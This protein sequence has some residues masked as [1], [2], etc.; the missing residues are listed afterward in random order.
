MLLLATPVVA[1]HAEDNDSLTARY[2]D[3]LRKRGLYT[4]AENYAESRL[5]DP[6]LTAGQRSEFAIQLSRT[7]SAH[8]AATG[9]DQQDEIWQRAAGVIEDALASAKEQ[10]QRIFLEAAAAFVLAARSE[11]LVWD[12]E[13]SPF[14]EP[15]RETLAQ[16]SA[17]ALQK[18]SAVETSL[19]GRLKSLEGK[20]RTSA[21]VPIYA[22]RRVAIQV[23]LRSALVLQAK[24][25]LSPAG[26]QDR[27][28]D[29]VSAD[30]RYRKVVSSG[31]PDEQFAAKLGLITSNRLRDELDRAFEMLDALARSEK[32]AVDGRQDAIRLERARVLLMSRRPDAAGKEL[33]IIQAGRTQL[34]G[35]FWFVQFQ[36]LAAIKRLANERGSQAL[37]EE[38][39]E[40]ATAALEEVDQQVGGVWSR[41]CRAIWSAAESVERYGQRLAA[42]VAQ[43][44]G[45]YVAGRTEAAIAAYSTAA[46]LAQESNQPD[47]AM[48]LGATLTG[49]LAQD[50]RWEELVR[51]SRQLIAAN[52]A[53]AK[54]AEIDLLRIYGLGR[55]LDADPTEEHRAAYAQALAD[56]AR[57]YA[58][59]STISEVAYLQGRLAETERQTGTA[60]A[61]YDR[62]HSDHVRAAVAAAA[63]AR[64]G[65]LQL[66]EAREAGRRDVA[67][68]KS[69]L[70]RL[71]QKLEQLPET[72]T[73]WN[74]AQAELTY[75]AVKAL[76]LVEP[77]RLADAERWLNRL[78]EAVAV[79]GEDSVS[80]RRAEL[81][82][83]VGPLRL[84]VLAGQGKPPVPDQMRKTLF[85]AGPFELLAIVEELSQFDV[86]GSETA[87]RNLI[88][89]QLT[90][91]EMLD[92]RRSEL[93]SSQQQR[94]DLALADAYFATTQPT[95][96]L[97]VY[98]RMLDQSPRDVDM[99]RRV[100]Q[101]L[102]DRDEPECRAL[103]K[104]S[105]QR[106][107]RFLKQGS[108]DWLEARWHVIACCLRL[109]EREQAQKLLH[110]TKLLYPQLGG[111][112]LR[113][114]F[115]KLEAQLK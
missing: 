57:Q 34:P 47:L 25:R 84:V 2:F 24:A 59:S 3:Q 82:Q 68:E 94:L 66:L 104:T 78:E 86:R 62:V 16:T 48:D 40:R 13:A 55:L 38:L 77:P 99:A 89:T 23:Q 96:A 91:A 12:V 64:C 60:I 27:Q 111:D 110:V 61:A 49:I 85:R 113:D 52:P 28:N 69:F 114:R 43:A 109:G 53:H 42:L 108:E 31:E 106:V 39:N 112:E 15:V 32:I 93:S 18:L 26:T 46:D 90:A 83:R 95:K 92:E 74:D 21:D 103:A 76:L 36:V 80:E 105:W 65:V 102:F 29:L 9:D 56:H 6:Q 7:L 72:A 30:E 107:E 22:L 35:D 51:R 98:Q 8:A 81:R 50:D 88:E 33:L 97:A 45:E 37:T 100:G 20:K 79:D 115:L 58:D 11:S 70:Q 19:A 1:V 63:L 67:L 87:R 44:Q 71:A 101:A 14:D 10:P 41:R 4:L 5:A 75:H 17:S 54:A 73:T